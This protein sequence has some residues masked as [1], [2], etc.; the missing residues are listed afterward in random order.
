MTAVAVRT[1]SLADAGAIA[2][3]GVRSWRQGF[4]GIV[5][6][7]IDPEQAWSPQR[8]AERLATEGE[9]ATTTLVAVREFELAGFLIHGGSRDAGAPRGTGEIWVLYVDPDHWRAGV[10]RSLVEAAIAQLAAAGFETATVWTLGESARNLAFYE[11]LG[12][13]RDGATQ[14]RE[15]FGR[16]L[17]VRLCRPLT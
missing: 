16:T 13:R 1:A 10:G 4:R 2:R 5:P 14:R 12:F 3:V 17:E 9:R 8:V 6:E 11:A 7:E 15:A